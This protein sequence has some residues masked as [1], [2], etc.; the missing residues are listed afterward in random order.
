MGRSQ[1]DSR[2]DPFKAGGGS[3]SRWCLDRVG[4]ASDE[5]AAHGGC[6]SGALVYESV[7]FGVKVGSR[8]RH[9]AGPGRPGE[10]ERN[11]TQHMETYFNNMAAEVGSADKLM[12]D[13]RTLV[14]DTEDL[15]RGGC[16]TAGQHTLVAVQQ[17]EDAIR[18]YPT[19]CV[20]LAFGVG[21]LLGLVL[22]RR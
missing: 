14:R 16:R 6:N 5:K 9:G 18:H 19:A 10:S 1:L 2:T 17:A 15:M 20:G 22:G 3:G 8:D 11:K 12:R 13:V 7:E 21:V 4:L